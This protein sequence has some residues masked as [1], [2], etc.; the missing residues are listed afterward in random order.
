I[1]AHYDLGNDFYGAWLDDTMTYSS[2]R[3]QDGID[4]DLAQAQGHKYRRMIEMTGAKRGDSVLEIG[5]GWG[6][7]AE[8]AAREGIE[9]EG[10]TL[11]PSQLDYARDRIVDAGLEGG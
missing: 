9:I 5:C 6:G 1:E 3:F 2:A 8:H 7:F 11:S 10:V 4:G